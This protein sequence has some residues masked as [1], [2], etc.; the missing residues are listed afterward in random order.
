M[1]TAEVEFQIYDR[2]AMHGPVTCLA[3]VGNFLAIGYASGTILV[4]NLEVRLSD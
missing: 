2:E 1:R 3:T 4:Y